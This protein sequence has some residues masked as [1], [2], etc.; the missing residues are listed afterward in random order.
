MSLI[1]YI[2]IFEIFPGF[3]IHIHFPKIRSR[4]LALILSFHSK[5]SLYSEPLPLFLD[6]G[7]SSLAYFTAMEVP[8]TT[9]EKGRKLIF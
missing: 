3:I 5:F 9:T 4:A 1:A 7:F 2:L 6:P 8:A